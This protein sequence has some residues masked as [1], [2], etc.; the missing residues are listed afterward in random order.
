MRTDQF[1]LRLFPAGLVA[2]LGLAAAASF[3]VL[4]VEDT[5]GQRVLALEGGSGRVIATIAL[6]S[7]PHGLSLCRQ[8]GLLFVASA[9]AGKVFVVDSKS[10]AVVRTLE[11]P[12]ARDPALS[13]DCARLYVPGGGSGR[14]WVFSTQDWQRREAEAGGSPQGVVVG[15]GWLLS[16]NF[17]DPGSLGLFD[18]QT[19][20]LERTLQVGRGVHSWALS[21]DGRWLALAALRSKQVLLLDARTLRTVATYETGQTP[22]GLAFRDADELWVS[23]LDA[24]YVGVAHLME[25]GGKAMLETRRYN[26]RVVTGRGP[27]GIAFSPDG[28]WAYVSNMREGTVARVDARTRRVVQRFSLGGEPHGLVVLGR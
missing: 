27:Y 24:D 5:L 4:Y 25:T 8:R 11:A 3:P 9:E 10:N 28:G 13:P 21:P 15:P 26:A 14:L 22:E 2:L 7:G 18:P 20:R 12:G 6:S 23:Y 19:L 17:G 16:L 1:W